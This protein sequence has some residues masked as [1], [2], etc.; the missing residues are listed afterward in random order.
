MKIGC[1]KGTFV[2]LKN[3][4]RKEEMSVSGRKYIQFVR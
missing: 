3:A 4:S 2:I 1:G